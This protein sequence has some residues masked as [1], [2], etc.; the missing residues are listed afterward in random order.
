[1]VITSI[2]TVIDWVL[3]GQFVPT[4][5]EGNWLRWLRMANEI[6]YIIPYV[7]Q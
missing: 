1:M 4:A 3:N 6:Q 2:T 5:G 7:P